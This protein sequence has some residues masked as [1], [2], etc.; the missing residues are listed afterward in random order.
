MEKLTEYL[1]FLIPL[2][3]RQQ[4]NSIR[5]AQLRPKEMA[6]RK[7][8]AGRTD[9]KTQQEVTKEIQEL[10][11]REKPFPKNYCWAEQ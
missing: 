4:K 6:I 1:P 8:Y 11:Q 2:A 9:Q 3:I 10:Y 5:Q 7:K